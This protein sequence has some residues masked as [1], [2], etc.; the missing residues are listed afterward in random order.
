MQSIPPAFVAPLP[1]AERPATVQAIKAPVEPGASSTSGNADR[2]DTQDP[3]LQSDRARDIMRAFTPDQAEDDQI[4]PGFPPLDTREVGDQ[5]KIDPERPAVRGPEP[6]AAAEEPT[7][8][9]PLPDAVDDPDPVSEPQSADPVEPTEPSIAAAQDRSELEDGE[10]AAPAPVTNAAAQPASPGA[11]A[12][13]VP[14]PPV[15]GAV[16]IRR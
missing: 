3:A 9:P 13:D 10:R 16:D 6:T 15:P 11:A 8:L 2:E 4:I 12:P 7:I 14:E 5:D 1:F